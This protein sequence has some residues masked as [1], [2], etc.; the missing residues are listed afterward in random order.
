MIPVDCK[1]ENKPLAQALRRQ[2][3]RQERRLW[4]CYLRTYPVQFRRQKQFGNYIVD[5]CCATANLGVEIDGSQHYMD[6][7]KEYD[8]E[9][10]T[11]LEGLGLKV[12][13][14]SNADVDQRFRSVC[15]YIDRIVRER[16]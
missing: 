10:S 6:A 2:M 9:R 15:E 5:F 7:G 12:V 1:P 16:K 13:R 14:V 11:Y 3:T 8:R 4:Y